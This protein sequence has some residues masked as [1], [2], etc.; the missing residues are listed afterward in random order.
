MKKLIGNSLK[1]ILPFAFGFFLIWYF[2]HSMSEESLNYFYKAIE[3][4]NYFWIILALLLSFI[5]YLS[6]A[7]RWKYT[8]ETLGHQPSFWNR[9][10][11][12][13]IG[14]LVNMTIPRAGEASRAAMLYRS[15]KIPFAQAFGTII[16]ER[17]VDFFML[18]IVSLITMFV[19]YDDFFE[20]FKQ[21][22]T[23]FSGNTTENAR[24]VKFWI[25]T[26]L[27]LA[28]GLFVFALMVLPKLR[29]KISTFIL[30]VFKGAFSIFKCKN[31]FLFLSHT[32]FIWVLYI[33]YFGIAFLSMEETSHFPLEGILMG[34]IAGALGISFTNGGIGTFPL[35]VGL[36]VVFYLN[37]TNPN[38]QAIGNA[39]GML[40]WISQTLLLI[41][42]GLIS[43]ILLPKN[44]S[45]E[46]NITK[47]V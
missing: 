12:M 4:A 13:M 40:I 14:Y 23:K 28:F 43:L 27:I 15:D 18:I 36:V 46:T 24:N 22:N 2:F 44:Y 3:K 10:H 6:R 39:L 7:Y 19:A 37:D 31:P 8:L 34:F 33:V 41:I 5:A 21:I 20:I 9:Y 35:L 42:L 30:N 16:A 17:A 11:A 25:L 1:I 38:A 45:K 26:I 47:N 29:N 32:I